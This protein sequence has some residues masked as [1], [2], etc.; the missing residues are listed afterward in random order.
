MFCIRIRKRYANISRGLQINEQAFAASRHA[1]P[2]Q[3]SVI[4]YETDS[5]ALCPLFVSRRM[6]SPT[7]RS[8]L[9]SAGVQAFRN[10][11]VDNAAVIIMCTIIGSLGL[12]KA[13]PEGHNRLA[14]RL[15]TVPA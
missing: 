2:S 14:V 11:I 1:T 3:P 6:A 12:I 5:F 9:A 13:D 4:V 8:D 7:R 10:I 15:A